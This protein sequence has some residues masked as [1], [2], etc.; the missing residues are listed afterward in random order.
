MFLYMY[1]LVHLYLLKQL[2][3]WDRFLEQMSNLDSILAKGGPKDI[4]QVKQIH[5]AQSELTQ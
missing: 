4:L 3:L 5:E 2:F 1:I